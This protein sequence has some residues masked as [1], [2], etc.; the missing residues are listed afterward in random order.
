MSDSRSAYSEGDAG[1]R[2]GVRQSRTADEIRERT[3]IVEIIAPHVSLKR[4]GKR[5]AGL[6][7]FH[8]DKAP[9]FT[10]DPDKGLW[11]CFGCGAG[12][13]VF[14]FL[15]RAENLTFPEAARKLADRLG[16]EFKGRRED[17]QARGERDLL[18]RI[19]G[20]AAGFFRRQLEQCAPARHYLT[21][22]G[23]SDETI[24][25]FM[26]GWAPAEW[27][28][29]YRHLRRQG[30]RDADIEKTG[31]CVPRKGGDG[32]YDRFRARIMFPILDA[33]ERVIAFS[34]R[35]VE[36]YEPIA[37]QDRASEP[38]GASPKAL[39]GSAPEQGTASP[40]YI[41]SPETALFRK[42]RTLYAFPL[43][44][45]A[46]GDRGRAILVEGQFDVIACHAAGFT[47]TVAT[48]G[49]ALTED[50]VQVLRRHTGRVYAAY[51]SDSAGMKAVL[52]SQELFEA[53][54][55]EVRIVCLPQGADPDSFLRERGPEALAAEIENALTAMDYRLAT[56]AAGHADTDEGQLAM[57]QEAVEALTGLRDAVA[58][59]HYIRRLAERW[60]KGNVDR[61]RLMEQALHQEL[62]KRTP[63][64]RR[65]RVGPAQP[66][67][68][69]ARVER[70]VLSAILQSEV[71]ARRLLGELCAEDF[72][73]D[74]HRRVFERLIEK[75]EGSGALDVEAMLAAEQEPELCSVVSGLAMMEDAAACSDA[76]LREAV[77]R[78][79][80]WRDARRCKE[81]LEKANLAELTAEELNELT[82]LRRRRSRLTQ[83]RSLGEP[84]G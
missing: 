42:G 19:N 3:N 56:I 40:K 66:L 55:L 12:G 41:N 71:T 54:P 34:G 80:E 30:Y 72:C 21:D 78:M 70:L 61:V 17:A 8:P 65:A 68:A 57:M 62:R 4:A 1:R 11:H 10:V 27:D 75:V 64:G 84:M 43:A 81:L 28:A 38:G 39:Q 29:L 13:N 49:T 83:R 44:R 32:C 7:P 24:A 36:G 31:L 45:K 59:T 47:E 53:A 51:D 33:D 15:M 9:S 50:H 48:L 16:I 76:E 5:L 2:S 14:N 77:E 73:E 74:I 46:M 23:Q 82:E 18:A 25:R 6:C 58:Q 67:N 60:C 63:R 52:R 79:R 37:R 69:A 20:E 22:R 35:I 26:L